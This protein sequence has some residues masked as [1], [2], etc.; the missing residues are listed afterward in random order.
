VGSTVVHGKIVEIEAI[1]D[2]DRGR[3][4]AAAVLEA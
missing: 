3:R 2:R 1:A 4:S